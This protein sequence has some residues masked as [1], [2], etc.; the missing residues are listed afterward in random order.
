LSTLS[1]GSRN[2]QVS[3]TGYRLASPTLN[4]P[5]VTLV[6]RRGD[7]APTAGVSVTNTSPDIYTEGLQVSIGSASSSFT[8]SGGIA[9]LVAGGTDAASLQVALNT[10]TAGAFA[11]TANVNFVSTGA[12]TTGAQDV[13]I[14]NA[15]VNLAGRVYEKAVAQVNTVLVNFG[16]VHKGDVVASQ[17]IGV[18]NAA[19]AAGLNDVLKGSV[20]GATGPFTAAGDLGAG[21]GAGATDNTS[22]TVGLNTDNAGVF[23][24]SALASFVSANPE[25][26]DLALGDAT[27][28][29]SAQVNNYADANLNKT[30]GSGL[31]SGGGNVFTL[32]FGNITLG[33]GPLTAFL[34]VQNDVTGPSD[35]LDGSF[36]FL[37]SQDFLY[38]MLDPFF[39]LGAGEAH[40]FGVTFNATALGLFSDDILLASLGHNA[41]GYSGALDDITL[42]IRG[43]VVSAHVPEPGTLALMIIALAL[44]ML[45][46]RRQ[47]VPR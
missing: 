10:G 20:G 44:L 28:A 19:P 46:H 45:M 42:R 38:S 1:L 6:A 15:V 3:G 30:S 34:N 11:D 27:I 16:I 29:L 41:S 9:N 21:L 24:G 13:G 47:Q 4:T 26:A 12:G 2:I 32:D 17:G 25:L 7:A 43:N 22:L 33:S 35:L 36:S 39:N 37:D 5:S 18:T 40:G 14:G 23:N 31:F 8:A